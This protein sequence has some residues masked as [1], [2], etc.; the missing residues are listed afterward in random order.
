[1]NTPPP[2]QSFQLTV[3]APPA[4]TGTVTSIPQ[5]IN[6]PTTCSASFAQGTQVRLMA[7]PGSNYFFGGWSGACSGSGSCN[8][9]MAGAESVNA[10]FTIGETLTVT[11]S[12]SGTGTV[13]STPAGI[14]CPTTCTASFPQNTNVTLS[15]AAGTNDAFSSWSGACTGSATCSVTLGGADSVTANFASSSGGGSVTAVVFVSS[16]APGGNSG[17]MEVLT[18]DSSGQL[19]AVPG[20]PFAVSLFGLAVS[21]NYLFGT[22]GT[23]LYSYS[24]ASDGAITKAD[25]IDV[26]QYNNP[27]N[28]SGGPQFLFLD[29]TGSTLYDLDSL[30][31][32]ANN[33]YQSVSV[34][35]ATGAL[36]YLGMTSTAS[37]VFERGLSFIGNNEFA[38]G[39]SC[40]HLIP[41]VYGFKRSG[42]GTL[43]LASGIGTIAPTPSGGLYCAWLAAADTANHLAVSVV[44][45]DGSTMHQSGPPQIAVYSVDGAGNVTT[46]STAA[47]MPQI[48]GNAVNDMEMSPTGTFL[49]VAE[50]SGFQVF[51]FN[52]ADPVTQLTGLLTSDPIDEVRWDSAGH[53]YA[54]SDSAAKVYVFTVSSGGATPSLGSPYAIAGPVDFVV[55][56][57]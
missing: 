9:T 33:S 28:C 32:C 37:P 12:G 46:N 40:Y 14:N 35:G 49:A 16:N 6:C 57:K 42:D 50:N 22:D 25:S 5:G 29:R 10:A 56:S 48:A 8:I 44:P 45:I 41:D 2:G 1:M 17:Q 23:N 21:G 43:T 3:G 30:S 18:A 54:M 38:F 19:T 51:N 53:L 7:N 11:I 20:S 27:L 15:A 39:A 47:N 13:T 24:V 52:G 4:G 31:D 36:T 34:N 55:L 26:R